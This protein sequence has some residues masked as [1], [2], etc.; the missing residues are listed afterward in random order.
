MIRFHPLIVYHG[1]NLSKQLLDNPLPPVNY[2]LL[3]VFH[4]EVVSF[5]LDGA[6]WGSP[7]LRC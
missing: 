1:F 5:S 6:L 4:G 3:C 7:V 2:V